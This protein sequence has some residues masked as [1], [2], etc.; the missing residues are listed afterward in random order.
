MNDVWLSHNM[1]LQQFFFFHKLTH[2]LKYLHVCIVISHV[3]INQYT[4]QFPQC[5]RIC[6]IIMSCNFV[7]IFGDEKFGG[8]FERKRLNVTSCF[9]VATVCNFLAQFL[10]N[11]K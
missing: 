3:A 7:T 9:N 1:Q 4:A 5:K 11:L 6:L 10:L 8:K 2:I